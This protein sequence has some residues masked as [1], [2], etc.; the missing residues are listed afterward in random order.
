MRVET[1]TSTFTDL[2][3]KDVV[4]CVLFSGTHET[5]LKIYWYRLAT[6]IT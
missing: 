6:I 2:C 4:M 5:Y 3:K 1:C